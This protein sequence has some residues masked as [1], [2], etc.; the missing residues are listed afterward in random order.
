MRCWATR[1]PFPNYVAAIDRIN[2]T[3]GSAADIKAAYDNL[4]KVLVETSFGIATN[5]YDI[6]LLVMSPKVTGV[7]QDIDNMLVA[8]TL[9]FNA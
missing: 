3:F 9:G 6:G 2:A 5:T 1:N 8:R 7:T 4:N